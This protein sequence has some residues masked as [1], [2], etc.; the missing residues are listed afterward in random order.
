MKTSGAKR[1]ALCYVKAL[2]DVAQSASSLDMVE[3]DMAALGDVLKESEDFR[4]FL[5]NPLL[6]RQAQADVMKALLA[7]KKGH[8]VTQQFMATL[9]RHRRFAILPEI[10]ELFAE[11][12]QAARGEM[13][14]QLIA[15]SA[16]K[17]KQI[18][19]V[20][21][22]LSQAYRKKVNL[23]V[24]QDASLLGGVMIKVGSVQLDA[25]LA[26]KLERLNQILRTA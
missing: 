18:E 1:I 26:G 25:S 9:A 24:R 11:A 17:S 4:H 6:S 20:G 5:T 14:A 15:A 10:I 2:F 7:K 19:L 3:K 21:E 23:D 12:A 13:K 16:L 22:R 8:K